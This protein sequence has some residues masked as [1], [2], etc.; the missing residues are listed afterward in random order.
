MCTVCIFHFSFASLNTFLPESVKNCL[1]SQSR[2][3]NSHRTEI[4]NPV[5]A[6]P[7]MQ[8]HLVVKSNNPS[9]D[10]AK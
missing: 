8:Q 4:G 10:V 9:G 3:A 1:P 6:E 7:R 2:A 5:L